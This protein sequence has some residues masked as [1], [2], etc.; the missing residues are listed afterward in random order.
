[1]IKMYYQ[2]T[3]IAEITTADKIYILS[4]YHGCI[5]MVVD[6]VTTLMN[7]TMICC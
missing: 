2:F 3:Y 5:F 1:M 6:K 7:L 4:I